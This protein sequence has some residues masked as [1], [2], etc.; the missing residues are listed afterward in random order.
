M[1]AFQV[2]FSFMLALAIMQTTSIQVESAQAYPSVVAVVVLVPSF[3]IVVA[4]R[5][6]VKGTPSGGLPRAKMKFGLR[7][8]RHLQG[9]CVG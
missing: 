3:V 5:L 8:R 7:R 6:I 2:L 1:T 4:Q 9:I